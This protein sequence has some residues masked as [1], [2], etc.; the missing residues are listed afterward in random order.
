MTG[1]KKNHTKSLLNS[2]SFFHLKMG[3]KKSPEIKNHWPKPKFDCEHVAKNSALHTSHCVSCQVTIN[4]KGL[5]YS[6]ILLLASVTLTVSSSSPD[7]IKHRSNSEI[8]YKNKQTT[9]RCLR[10][11]SLTYFVITQQNKKH[12]F[13]F[14]RV[15]LSVR[16]SSGPL[17]PYEPLEAGPQAGSLPPAA[18]RCLPALLHRF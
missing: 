6:V 2:V 18:V 9:H 16:N 11:F 4:S 8:V 5:V 17:C 12:L 1:R 10:P 7:V 13:N 3:G 15:P 14:S